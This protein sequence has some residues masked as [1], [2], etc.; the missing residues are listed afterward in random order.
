M[1]LVSFTL[2]VDSPASQ[3]NGTAFV[4]VLAAALPN[5]TDADVAISVS[6]VGVPDPIGVQSTLP[7]LGRRH[8]SHASSSMEHLLIAV[9]VA[10]STA[11]STGAVVSASA[12]TLFLNPI[13][14]AATL[15][16]SSLVVVASPMSLRVLPSELSTA[17][18]TS[19]PSTAYQ[20]LPASVL[21]TLPPSALA[22][23]PASVLATLPTSALA[24]LP[25]AIRQE[26]HVSLLRGRLGGQLLQPSVIEWPLV[27]ALELSAVSST[28][29]AAVAVAVASSVV[30][31]VGGAVVSAISS[32]AS[33]GG[34]AAGSSSSSSS[35]A[36]GRA[37]LLI[38][39]VQ[40]LALRGGET[41][42]DQGTNA[43]MGAALGR[44]LTPFLG[45]SGVWDAIVGGS[46]SLDT[47]AMP[48]RQLGEEDTEPANLPLAISALLDLSLTG[49]LVLL[50]VL[51]LHGLA[52]CIWSAWIR[53]AVAKCVSDTAGQQ[54]PAFHSG[55]VEDVE[56]VAV[57]AAV[58]WPLWNGFLEW[59]RVG[60]RRVG[61]RHRRF[62][63]PWPRALVGWKPELAVF[64]FFLPGLSNACF[65]VWTLAVRSESSSTPIPYPNMDAFIAY[66]SVV[67]A[68]MLL[69]V[70]V[71]THQLLHLYHAFSS[72]IWKGTQ[73]LDDTSA[74]E[75]PLCR[76]LSYV[77]LRCGCMRAP[78]DRYYGACSAPAAP[79]EPADAIEPARSER[80]LARRGTCPGPCTKGSSPC[81][82]GS[83]PPD[84]AS[85]RRLT[86]LFLEDCFLG[87]RA[88]RSNETA[89]PLID[90]SDALEAW[91]SFLDRVDAPDRS[92][93]A[94]VALLVQLI[95]A[96]ILASSSPTAIGPSQL[97]P[98]LVLELA[99]GAW[100]LI[101]RPAAD[102]LGCWI[103]GMSQLSEAISSLT[104]L[105]A[106]FAPGTVPLLSQVSA[107][108]LLA[109]TV[110]LPALLTYYDNG[111]QYIEFAATAR[112]RAARLYQR[113][114]GRTSSLPHPASQVSTPPLARPPPPPPRRKLPFA[115]AAAAAAFLR[116]GPHKSRRWRGFGARPLPRP[117]AAWDRQVKV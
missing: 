112:S 35:D 92:C 89:Q 33:G 81:T 31:T 16:V 46:E 9:L 103:D 48:R 3:F 88:T 63:I 80:L 82:K 5:V 52:R 83:S 105:I 102:R 90:A 66:A 49:V 56:D 28:V 115:A 76:A 53:W 113:L 54:T 78:I 72:T 117:T 42:S 77:A 17:T 39:G 87:N 95:T 34:A 2:L 44:A 50:G 6:T 36:S 71:L 96:A 43:G 73:R 23:L 20:T 93:A 11:A 4:H 100:I 67:L 91:S 85:G 21:A 13:P 64:V 7:E 84:S 101:R 74:V 10:L 61:Q 59:L 1:N 57:V 37:V 104:L 62:F 45:A 22:S 32:A 98:L 12:S 94:I 26:L 75:D 68:L 8:L 58:E 47:P 19:L 70:G 38:M 18:L 109:G 106:C 25:L 69:I 99:Y 116:S 86:H 40:R 51:L 27:D 30:S 55:D 29:A 107:Y 41:G 114:C 14:A 65:A 79:I 97:F 15:G 60:Q 111:L 110:A 24:A 108:S